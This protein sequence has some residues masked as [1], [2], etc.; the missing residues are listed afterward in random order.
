M[1]KQVPA[2]LSIFFFSH[3]LHLFLAYIKYYLYLC[4]RKG[5][6]TYQPSAAQ[7]VKSGKSKLDIDI[8][9]QACAIEKRNKPKSLIL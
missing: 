6:I 2:V 3:F 1:D 9:A 7:D 5:L 4:T 8:Q